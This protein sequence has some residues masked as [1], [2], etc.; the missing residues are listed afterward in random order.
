MRCLNTD[1]FTIQACSTSHQFLLA[2]CLRRYPACES[3][4]W[5]RLQSAS[6][7]SFCSSKWLEIRSLSA[8]RT[9]DSYRNASRRHLDGLPWVESSEARSFWWTGLRR[10]QDS[11]DQGQQRL[12]SRSNWPG[13]TCRAYT[14]TCTRL[15][16]STQVS[17]WVS[18]GGLG[19]VRDYLVVTVK[20]KSILW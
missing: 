5:L 2:S 9:S 17:P 14:Q 8:Y 3:S 10:R 16:V 15:P 19:F 7:A 18:I 20:N 13:P 6:S 1:L 12:G 4:L 11:N